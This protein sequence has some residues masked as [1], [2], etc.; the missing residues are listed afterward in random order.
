MR[1]T[2]YLRPILIKVYHTFRVSST[3]IVVFSLF[4]NL[5]ILKLYKKV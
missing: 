4:R 3:R 5:S 1:Q 2:Q